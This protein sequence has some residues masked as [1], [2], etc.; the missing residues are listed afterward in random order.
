LQYHIAGVG[1]FQYR[2]LSYTRFVL[3][4]L[5]KLAAS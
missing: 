4:G 2:L 1:S 3:F 5:F